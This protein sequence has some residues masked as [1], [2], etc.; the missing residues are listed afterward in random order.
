M[1]GTD[2]ES[3]EQE[4]DKASL[5]AD[6][7]DYNSKIVK[8]LREMCHDNTVTSVCTSASKRKHTRNTKHQIIR[9]LISSLCVEKSLMVEDIEIVILPKF[10]TTVG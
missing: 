4:T 10:I 1:A 2:N 6:S 9:N 5:K 7:Q 3:L 8:L